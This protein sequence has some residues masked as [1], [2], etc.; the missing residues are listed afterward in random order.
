MEQCDSEQC[1]SMAI[2]V[3]SSSPAEMPPTKRFDNR[4]VLIITLG[5]FAV[6]CFFWIGS[7]PTVSFHHKAPSNHATPDDASVHRKL[8]VYERQ[9]WSDWFSDNYD[10]KGSDTWSIFNRGDGLVSGLRCR[11]N[12]CDDLQV[13]YV[14]PANESPGRLVSAYWTSSRGFT[15]SEEDGG[16]YICDDGHFFSGL[17]CVSV[18]GGCA[19]A[20]HHKR[21]P[22]PTCFFVFQTYSY[23]QETTAIICPFAVADSRTDQEGLASGNRVR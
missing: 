14:I 19:N 8:A 10:K 21:P 16:E 22:H 12:Y 23:S 7:P 20:S 13:R 4:I 3:D 2:V 18:C 15:L 9:E 17:S 6:A 5:A 1:K 11:N